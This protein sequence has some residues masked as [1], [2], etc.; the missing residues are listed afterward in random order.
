M[1]E[2]Q[3]TAAVEEQQVVQDTANGGGETDTKADVKVDD[4]ARYKYDDSLLIRVKGR[5]KRPSK[6]DEQ[7][8]NLACDKLKA[9]IEK[10][11][12]RIKEIKDMVESSRSART[13]GQSGNQEIIRRLTALRQEFQTVLRQKQHIREELQQAI[14]QKEELRAASRQLRDKLPKGATAENLESKIEEL[15][16][17]MAHEGGEDDKLLFK[18]IS[19]LKSARPAFKESGDIEAK[20][21]AWEEKRAEIQHRLQQC[22]AVLT[23]VK[24]REEEERKVLEQSRSKQAETDLDVPALNVEKKECW[25]IIQA[26]RAKMDE[27]RK[28]FQ[29]RWTEYITLDR[30]YNNYM[31]SIKRSQYEERQKARAERDAAENGVD[32]ETGTS[33]GASGNP[34]DAVVVEAYAAEVLT[35]DQLLLH[36]RKLMPSDEKAAASEEEK[37]QVE[38]PKGMKL[39]KKDDDLGFMSVTK[40]KAQQGKKGAA[41]VAEVA[42]TPKAPEPVRSKKLNHTFEA[43]KTFMQFGLEVPQT[44]AELPATIEKAVAKKEYYLELRRTGKKHV[45]VAAAAAPAPP[46]A[47]EENIEP[48]SSNGPTTAEPEVSTI[49]ADAASSNGALPPAEDVDADGSVLVEAAVAEPIAIEEADTD[50]DT[51]VGS[52]GLGITLAVDKNQSVSLKLRISE[53]A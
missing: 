47:T 24:A 15:E 16:Y 3:E 42:A 8:R 52:E 28:D 48:S 44:T 32:G 7:E 20:L 51:S 35:L 40:K 1:A 2:E 41:P 25:D 22:D 6:P 23:D 18:R 21:K 45:P 43:L 14:K 37:K 50:A 4:E 11:S 39:L 10:R 19:D 49:N 30:N 17:K 38:V 26:L 33:T 13:A 12:A 27:I 46:P 36:L 31:R 5:V 29:A 53:T 9:E 34:A